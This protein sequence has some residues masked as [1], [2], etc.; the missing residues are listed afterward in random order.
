MKLYDLKKTEEGT[1]IYTECSDDSKYINF[2]HIDGMY[3]YCESE[4]GAVVHL[5][6]GTEIEEYKDG[7]K[8][9]EIQQPIHFKSNFPYK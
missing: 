2:F 6:C 1:K 7:Y 4:K 3:S 5:G 9:K 8:I